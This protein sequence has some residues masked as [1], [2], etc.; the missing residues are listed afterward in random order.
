MSFEVITWIVS[1]FALTG[2]IL[3][4]NRNKYGFA[5][6]ICTNL[7]W[8]VVDFRAGLYAQSALYGAYVILAIRGLLTWSKKE[9]ADDTA[10]NVK[11]KY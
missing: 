2:T 5:I 7:F 9:K 8:L 3:N 11:I 10:I 1:L 6:W 4:S